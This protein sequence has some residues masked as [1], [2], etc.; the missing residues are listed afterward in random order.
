MR[1]SFNFYRS[2]SSTALGKRGKYGMLNVRGGFATYE[3]SH[4]SLGSNGVYENRIRSK[5]GSLLKSPK[6]TFMGP[7]LRFDYI[8]KLI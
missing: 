4:Q 5:D 6:T 8:S 3:I 7:M 1:Y 2:V